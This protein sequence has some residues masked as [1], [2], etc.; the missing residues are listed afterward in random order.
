M[1]TKGLLKTNASQ[2]RNR[3][4]ILKNFYSN[5]LERDQ[6]LGKK[7]KHPHKPF[8]NPGMKCNSFLKRK[9]AAKPQYV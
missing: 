7:A 5:F 4:E 1:P 3:F 2:F 9:F 6:A 8:E